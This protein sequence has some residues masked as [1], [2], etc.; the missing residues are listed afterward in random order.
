MIKH[1]VVMVTLLVLTLSL[2]GVVSASDITSSDVAL[3][4]LN[5]EDSQMGIVESSVESYGDVESVVSVS[6]SDDAV[7]SEDISSSGDELLVEDISQGNGE[8]LVEDVS[9]S[10]SEPLFDDAVSIDESDYVLSYEVESYT[11]YDELDYGVENLDSISPSG[12][13]VALGAIDNN[14]IDE[15]YK[16]GYDVTTVAGELVDFESA[17]D[18]LVI[19]TVDSIKISDVAV[20]N[21]LN[22]IIDASNG[23]VTKNGNLITLSSLKSDLI[24]IAFFIRKCESL[25]RVFYEN[26]AITS[27][28]SDDESSEISASLWEKVSLLLNDDGLVIIENSGTNGDFKGVMAGEYQRHFLTEQV[29][30][31]DLIQTLL[32]CN[33]ELGL[34]DNNLLGVSRDTDDNG[35]ICYVNNISDNISYVGV[36]SYNESL[37][38]F[39]MENKTSE[40]GMITVLSY[41]QSNSDKKVENNLNPDINKTRFKSS[42]KLTSADIKQIGVDASKKAL[43]YFKSR[44][45]NV[46]KD[47]GNLYVLTSAGY[48]KINGVNTGRAIDGI[49]SVFGPE[50][51]KNIYLIHTSL[52]KDL[53]F[54]FIWVNSANNREYISYSLKY[55]AGANELVEDAKSKSEG[56]YFAYQMGLYTKGSVE[57]DNHDNHDLP[58]ECISFD[59]V[60]K[61][62]SV[63]K[64]RNNTNNNTNA[65]NVTNASDAN[66]INVSLPESNLP[67][68]KVNPYNIVY[69]LVSILL[70]CGIFGVSY[71]KR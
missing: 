25:Y 19:L 43:A 67:K 42:N 65:S 45:I 30:G 7:L 1:G 6:S 26:G 24:D 22:G 68:S 46:K 53:I 23:Y 44:G 15:N 58:Q 50:I 28:C 54:Y 63:N 34:S 36:D 13:F 70:V 48:A 12:D 41:N 57:P 59:I 51:R 60:D 20:E 38:G 3:Q 66:I 9:S 37:I 5:Q 69:T 16:L 56:D 21:V 18:I 4:S 52:W 27:I 10:E 62:T 40:T 2:L 29:F 71:S 61:I 14:L 49:I 33:N 31:Q 55:D 17:D 47:Y 11:S 8:A 64:D 39:S 32:G 35:L